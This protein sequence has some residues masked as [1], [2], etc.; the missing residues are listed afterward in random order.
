MKSKH[1]AF[2]FMIDGRYMAFHWPQ[3]SQLERIKHYA[4]DERPDSF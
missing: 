3:F 1:E 2:Y 4:L